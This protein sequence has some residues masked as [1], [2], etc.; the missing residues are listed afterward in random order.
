M[1]RCYLRRG[2]THVSGC[3]N[4]DNQALPDFDV[5]PV[6]RGFGRHLKK[7]M[8][9]IVLLKCVCMMELV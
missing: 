6:G 3:L 7:L 9:V 2:E 8:L 5:V 4:A 1:I